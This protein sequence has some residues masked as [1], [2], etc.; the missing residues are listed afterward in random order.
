M[1]VRVRVHGPGSGSRVRVQVQV[2][3]VAKE[4]YMAA[5]DWI[6]II[7]FKKKLTLHS[8]EVSSRL[9]QTRHLYVL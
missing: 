5:F 2:L 3:E 8:V 4:N 6:K 7:T 9:V 1:F